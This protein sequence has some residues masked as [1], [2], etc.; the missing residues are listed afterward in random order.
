MGDTELTLWA[1]ELDLYGVL[2]PALSKTGNWPFLTNTGDRG[3]SSD[4]KGLLKGKTLKRLGK[5]ATTGNWL[6]IT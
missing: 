1:E 2:D 5:F 4:Q 6:L 3:S